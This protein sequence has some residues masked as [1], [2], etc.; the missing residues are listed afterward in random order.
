MSVGKR[1]FI[2]HML[3]LLKLKNVFA[4]KEGD[5]PAITPD[6]IH[7]ARPEIIFLSS[8]PFPFK[9]KHLSEFRELCPNARIELV[10]GEYF[11]WYGSR[12]ADAPAYFN[13]LFNKMGNA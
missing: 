7:K 9:E 11:S 5:Y 6:D 3:E 2:N 1:S 8:E 4:D 10:D 12:L 13:N